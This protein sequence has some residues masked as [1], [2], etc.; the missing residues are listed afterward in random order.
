[1]NAAIS[2][3]EFRAASPVDGNGLVVGVSVLTEGEAKG[4]GIYIDRASIESAHRIAKGFAGG[5]KVKMEHSYGVDKIIGALRSFRIDGRQL[6]ADL[7]LLMSHPAFQFLKELISQ[8]PTTFGLSI[9]FSF[10]PERIEK[11][12]F[13]RFEDIYS[14]DI[15]DRPAANP[16]GLFSVG[17]K[18]TVRLDKFV[19]DPNKS[20]S[21]VA[22]EATRGSFRLV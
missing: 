10:V 22:V 7:H 13:V 1:M 6:R 20:A 8:Q 3:A 15:V 18:S 12:D 19:Y 5:V 16:G 9:S 17:P 21:G 14:V 2:T 4:H 11:K